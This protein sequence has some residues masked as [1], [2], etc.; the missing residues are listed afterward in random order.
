M[1]GMKGR[2]GIVQLQIFLKN[3]A[4]A[5]KQKFE[6][7]FI[8]WT[9]NKAAHSVDVCERVAFIRARFLSVNSNLL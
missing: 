4:V 7:A 8:D 9:S 6:M 2:K 3:P 5:I 1:K